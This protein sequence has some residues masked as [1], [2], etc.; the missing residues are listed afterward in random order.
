MELPGSSGLRAPVALIAACAIQVVFAF[1]LVD[2]WRPPM[3]KSSQPTITAWILPAPV[4]AAIRSAPQGLGSRKAPRLPTVAVPQLAVPGLS[5]PSLQPRPPGI[6][7]AAAAARAAQ[8]VARADPSTS[9]KIARTQ[10]A[11]QFPWSKPQIGN[12]WIHFDPE[13]FVTSITFGKRCAV[14]LFLV[15]LGGGCVIGHI[16]PDSGQ[17]DLF[18]PKYRVPQ[19]ELPAP[20]LPEA[21]PGQLH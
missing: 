6:D 19:L 1:A 17:G 11:A 14:A 20:A 18:D 2:A 7:W 15:V 3:S 13:T 12:Q 21:A 8:E 9:G 4:P 10:P 16:D 5:V